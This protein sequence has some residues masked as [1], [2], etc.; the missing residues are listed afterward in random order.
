MHLMMLNAWGGRLYDQLLPYLT[1]A[2]PDVLCLQEVV[3]T[4]AS[5]APWLEYR[6]AER[7]LP[8]RA[9]LLAEVAAILPNHVVTFC[10]AARGH[11]FDGALAVPSFSGIAT[12]VRQTHPI[13]GQVQDF[14]HDDFLPDRY[15]IHPYPR[16]AHIVRVFDDRLGAA[17]TVAHMHG[18]RDLTAKADTIERRAQAHR[19][20]QLI[21]VLRRPGERVVVCGDFNVRPGSETLEIFADLGLTDLVTSHGYTG[22]RTVHYEKPGRFADYMMVSPEVEVRAF[23]VV[24]EPAVSDHAAL[25]LEIG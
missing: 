1:S 20:A 17:I 8:Q 23:D 21:G 10:P 22:T 18:L 16:A 9:N 19:F 2:D 14:V 3:H 15:G 12:F 5:S 11:L 7:T 24:S 13:V 6:D 25:T 4:P